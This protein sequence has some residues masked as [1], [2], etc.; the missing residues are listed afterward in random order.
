MGLLFILKTWSL[1]LFKE[2]CPET[3]ATEPFLCDSL[4]FWTFALQSFPLSAQVQESLEA[5]VE[6]ED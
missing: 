3:C 2:K 6:G 5:T 4:L 1:S